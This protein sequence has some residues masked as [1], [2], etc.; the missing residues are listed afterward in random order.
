M[1]DLSTLTVPLDQHWFISRYVIW[2]GP[3]NNS[4]NHDNL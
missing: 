2:N 4:I 3:D 1:V